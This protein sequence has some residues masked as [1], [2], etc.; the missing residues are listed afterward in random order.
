AGE[1][2]DRAAGVGIPV[3]RAESGK[4]GD[5]G[6]AAGVGN[7][8]GEGFDFGGGLDYSETVA[9]PLDEGTGDEDAAFESVFDFRADFPGDGGDESVL[10]K[11]RFFTGV[12]ED[13]AA[14]A[15][16]VFGESGSAAGLAEKGGVLVAGDS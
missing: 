2:E 3:G 14:G 1:A 15:V 6:D 8:G 12:H 16:G 4:G 9:E 7:A 13:E 11:D 5:D 10:R